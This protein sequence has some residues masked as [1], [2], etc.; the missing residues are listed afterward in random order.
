[1]SYNVSYKRHLAKT[2]TY[3]ILSSTISF[4]IVWIISG[5]FKLGLSLSFAEVMIKPAQYFIHERIWYK[6]VKFGLIPKDNFETKSIIIEE[7]KQD[8]LISIQNSQTT[9]KKVLSYNSNR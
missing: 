8:D 7:P 4:L 9:S 2:V 5:D 6:W 3:R 1:M